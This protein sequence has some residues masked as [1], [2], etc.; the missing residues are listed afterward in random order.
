MAPG[1]P[2]RYIDT[3]TEETDATVE[4]PLSYQTVS[5]VD[6]DRVPLKGLLVVCTRDLVPIGVLGRCIPLVLV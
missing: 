6:W 1:H 4:S 2:T 3:P 5:R